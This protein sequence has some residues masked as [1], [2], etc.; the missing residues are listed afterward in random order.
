MKSFRLKFI[1]VDESFSTA[2]VEAPIKGF[3]IC[4]A[5]KG[6][7]EAT[8]FPYG[9]EKTINAMIGLQTANWP[10]LYEAIAFNT[11]YGLYISAP[12]GTASNYAS[13]YGGVYLTAKSMFYYWRVDDK[14]EP[15]YEI[16]LYPGY[17][18]ADYDDS[19]P[20]SAWNIASINYTDTTQGVITISNIAPSLMAKINYFNFTCWEQKGTGMEAGQE[21]VYHIDNDKIYPVVDDADVTD[22]Q[23]GYTKLTDGTYTIVLGAKSESKQDGNT[24]YV[25]ASNTAATKDINYFDFLGLFDY[26]KA[27]ITDADGTQKINE[28]LTCDDT[29]VNPKKKVGEELVKYLIQYGSGGA[30]FELKITDGSSTNSWWCSPVVG[31][32]DR[33]FYRVNIKNDCYMRISQKSPNETPTSITISNIGYDKYLYDLN[34]AYILKEDFESFEAG[35]GGEGDYVGLDTPNQCAVTKT[36][37][38][39]IMNDGENVFINDLARSNTDFIIDVIST[40]SEQAWTE[41]MDKNLHSLWQYNTTTGNWTD[42]TA[43]YKTKNFYITG[44]LICSDTGIAYSDD[45]NGDGFVHDICTNSI[46]TIVDSGKAG[47]YKHTTYQRT[48][49]G[50]YKLQADINHNTVTL[51][52]KEEVYPGSYMSG[53]EFTGSLSDTGVDASGANIYW[54]N[55]LPSNAASFIEVTP[56]HTFEELGVVNDKGF[57]T[58][59]KLVDPIGPAQDVKTF[60]IKGQRTMTNAIQSNIDAGTLGCAWTKN[61]LNGDGDTSVESV[62]AAA[63][64]QGIIEAQQNCYDDALVFMECS[65]QETF[66]SKL[67]SLRTTFHDTCT[68]IS[69]KMITKAEFNNPATITVAGRS[70]GTAQYVGEFKMYDTYT[71]KYYWCQPIGDVGVNLARIMEKKLGGVAPAG[72]NDS[73]GLG[74]VLSRAVLDKKW[75]FSDDALRIMDEKGINPITYDATNGLMMQSQKTTQDPANVTDWS[76]LGHSMSFDLCKREIRDNV[77]VKQ[78]H[79]RISPYYFNIRTKQVQAILDKR[80]T[81]TDPIWATATVDIAGVNT[82]QTMAQRKFMITVKVKV[83]PYSDYVVLTFV[84]LAQ[85]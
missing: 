69:P 78:L 52:C 6:T 41:P 26:S 67:M 65:G 71:G 59:D 43:D 81:G 12:P 74:G 25:K 28:T 62:F 33:G 55:I 54:P 76:Y 34:V 63:I 35:N 10:D 17:E 51:S 24:V 29:S 50:N 1:D 42:V 20:D 13:Y 79:K 37:K 82:P 66:K 47:K 36:M 83:Y 73:A 75:D 53:G 22:M 70:T 85:E 48:K 84:T 40:T 18:G 45:I 38:Q 60:T 56:V 11:E 49:D 2:T 44:P 58:G 39:D 7:T 57:F 8:Y 46:W 19:L 16:Q 5:P 64:N 27:V 61:P 9:N 15:S 72:T 80:I 31:L 14:D 21:M 23:V 68:I 30:K 77:M 32:E 4:R 3:M